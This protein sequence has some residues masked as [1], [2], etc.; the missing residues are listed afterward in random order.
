MTTV[1]YGTAKVIATFE[2]PGPRILK[3]DL[4]TYLKSRL[5]SKDSRID[6]RGQ[7]LEW[8]PGV[9]VLIPDVNGGLGRGHQGY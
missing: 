8:G 7:V 9:A 6:D 4:L 5:M 2:E 1:I 3:W